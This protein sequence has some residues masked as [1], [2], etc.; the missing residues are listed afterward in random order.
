MCQRWNDPRRDELSL[1]EYIKL[2]ED[3]HAMGSHQIS[4]S[5]GEPLLRSDVI[6]WRA[7]LRQV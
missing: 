1:E 2:A 5:G 6:P 7:G 4:I 3:L